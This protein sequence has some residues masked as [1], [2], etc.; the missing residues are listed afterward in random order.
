MSSV[1]AWVAL[2][3]GSAL[4]QSLELVDYGVVVPLGAAGTYT[5]YNVGSPSVAYDPAVGQLVM[6]FEYRG[7]WGDP[8]RCADSAGTTWGIGRA[9]SSDGVTWSVDPAPVLAPSEGSFWAC[10][11]VQPRVVY[12][13]PG[14]WHLWFKAFDET[15]ATGVGYASSADGVGF[16]VASSPALTVLDDPTP[17]D[18]GWPRVVQVS[19]T[20]MMLMNYGDNGITLATS[21]DPAGPFAWEGAGGQVAVGPGAY[22]WMEDELIVADVSC[23]DESEPAMLDL[24]FGGHDRDAQDFWGTPRSRSIGLGQALD[25]DTWT[26]EATPVE[27]W[28]QA[29]ILD[30][31]AWRSWSTVRLANGEVLVYYHRR[32]DGGNQVGLA[33]TSD[34]STWDLSTVE[35]AVCVYDGAAPV[36]ADDDYTLAQ[37]PVLVATD[38]VL[39]NDV[40]PERNPMTAALVDPPVVG[41]VAL[42]ADGTF[43]YTAPAGF[44]GEVT[45]TY[46]ASDASSSSA[47]AIVTV[48]VEGGPMVPVA[49]DDTYAVDRHSLVVGPLHGV[50]GNDVW[51][52][53]SWSWGTWF[54]AEAVLVQGPDHGR[55]VLGSRGGLLYVP[56]PGFEGL[57]QFTYEVVVG[58]D[59]SLPATVTLDVTAPRRGRWWR[60]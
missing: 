21:P 25:A 6:F 3:S 16:T 46:A 43:T 12:E 30:D 50:L 5:E 38:S 10:A 40:D 52:R 27:H 7:A 2:S 44:A 19:G 8:A 39:D 1:L 9:T 14:Q 28:D 17:E 15:G 35:P 33:A 60:R 51:E 37:G 36:A 26:I 34:P 55:L 22:P 32:V 41:T 56:D 54:G 42:D 57:D 24:V 47:P 58:A 53:T 23:N 13:G 31:T 4:A 29:A 49:L 11:A 59:V 18:F 20:W 45:F 48:V